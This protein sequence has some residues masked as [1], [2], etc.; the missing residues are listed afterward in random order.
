MSACFTIQQRAKNLWIVLVFL[1]FLTSCGDLL[2][3]N[4][5]P[6][7]VKFPRLLAVSLFILLLFSNRFRVY[8]KKL[9]FAFLWI[10][11]ACV[12]SAFF[13]CNAWRT[14][15]GCGASILA[16]V[17]FFLVPINLI[18]LF[19][20][21]R[22]LQLY[23]LSFVCVGL[24]ALMQFFLSFFGIR[25]PFVAQI[26]GG[27]ILIF[28]GQSW[29][30]EPTFYALFATPFVVFLNTRFLLSSSE[31]TPKIP[32]WKVLGSNA[33]LLCST[34]TG[35]FFSYFVFFALCF[36]F[37]LSCAYRRLFPLLRK[38]LVC[39]VLGFATAFALL[40]ILCWEVFLRSFYKFFHMGFFAHWSFLER[41]DKV[42]EGWK[43]FC[44][45]PFFGVGLRGVE[46]YL[47]L[48][49]HFN[50]PSVQLYGRLETRDTFLVYS[51]STVLMEILASLGVFGLCAFIALGILVW[52]MF[53]AL[54]KSALI[55]A[56][57]KKTLFSLFMSVLVMGVCMQFNQE[58]FRN[59]VWI[60]MGISL[61]YLLNVRSEF[62]Q[63]G[64]Y[65]QPS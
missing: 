64:A 2:E 30:Y 8:E 53:S 5:G 12:V 42:V 29:T 24:H 60:H 52:N 32:L 35:G 1:Y 50:D 18:F 44:R 38:R 45:Y 61:G 48:Q 14:L 16:Y 36:A 31:E 26:L 56:E 54:L 15:A 59:Y 6:I 37:T 27:E 41:W 10:L 23:W 3:V 25:D 47:Y 65:Q 17:G 19:G 20:R 7:S 62:Q 57:E 40:G 11:S 33:L 46:Q 55:P 43:I 4:A 51:S 28:R 34:S 63:A 49:A 22:I 9:F 21:A 58:L 39:F 13:S